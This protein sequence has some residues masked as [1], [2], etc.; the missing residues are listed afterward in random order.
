MNE[1]IAHR[2]RQTGHRQQYVPPQLPASQHR[3]G[4][5]A[6]LHPE[7]QPWLTDNFIDED[8]PDEPVYPRMPSSARR[9]Y[10]T[11]SN[12]A[13]RHENTRYEYHPDQMQRI[14]AR[15][16]AQQANGVQCATAVV[17]VV[18]QRRGFH[19]S[20]FMGLGMILMILG[21]IGYG[22][23]SS[24]WQLHQ[25]D[26]TYGRPRTAQYDVVVGH[27]D[28]ESSPTH[29]IA[30]NLNARIVIIEVP[31]GDT[32]KSRIY[33]GPQLFGQNADLTPVTLSFPDINND[34]K[35]HMVVH[36]QGSTLI[37]LNQNGQFVPQQSH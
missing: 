13:A 24:W 10:S 2:Y 32:S 4:H 21:W 29:I 22:Y 15:R 35:P 18:T 30:I 16:S 12:V 17:P 34:G 28:S 8:Y 37:Y 11:P 1:Q 27:G 14:P 19:W 25:D 31:G 36:F 3:V 9:Y 20:V 33:S 26:A 7:D 6:G 5:Q 23:V